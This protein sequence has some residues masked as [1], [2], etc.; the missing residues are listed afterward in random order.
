M[1][2]RSAAAIGDV[3]FLSLATRPGW[4]QES[5]GTILGRIT[6]STKLVVPGASVQITNVATT[7]SVQTVSNGAGN[8]SAPF[9]TPGTYR[10][11]VKKPGINNVV[12][13]GVV[14]NLNDRLQSN[15]PL[16]LGATSET[17]TVTAETPLLA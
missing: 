7:V 3:V 16:E 6:D 4:S 14:L 2:L 11:T 1:L 15:I 8:Y 5:Q 9:L 17:I 13:D 10:I 12:R